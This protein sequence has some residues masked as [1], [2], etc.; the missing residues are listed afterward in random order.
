[1]LRNYLV[2]K[3]RHKVMLQLGHMG[4][5]MAVRI[6]NHSQSFATAAVITWE[7]LDFEV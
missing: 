6:T 3:N 5:L 7:V 4:S 2:V 1:M